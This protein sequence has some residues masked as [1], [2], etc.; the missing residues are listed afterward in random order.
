MVLSDIDN[1]L[2]SVQKFIDLNLVCSICALPYFPIWKNGNYHQ[3]PGLIERR[4][5]RGQW[6]WQSINPAS[7]PARKNWHPFL[8]RANPGHLSR[9]HWCSWVVFYHR[10]PFRN[11][12]IPTLMPG[13]L[14]EKLIFTYGE[15]QN[16]TRNWSGLHKSWNPPEKKSE[17][18]SEHT[19]QQWSTCGGLLWH[20]LKPFVWFYVP[21]WSLLGPVALRRGRCGGKRQKWKIQ[22]FALPFLWQ[23]VRLSTFLPIGYYCEAPSWVNFEETCGWLTLG[24]RAG[25][26]RF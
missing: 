6:Q 4:T 3:F 19:N 25:K 20:V 9:P 17:V 14:R 18:K 13:I 5:W 10:K 21:E 8:R 7:Q 16:R 23:C 24:W 15:G 22:L 1:R 11:R 26:L 12:R 2:T